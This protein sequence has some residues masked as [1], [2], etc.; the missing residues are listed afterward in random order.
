MKGVSNDFFCKANGT[1][2]HATLSR[3]YRSKEVCLIGDGHGRHSQ[4]GAAPVATGYLH[5]SYASALAAFG[6]PLAL[7]RCQGWV[8]KRPIAGS[9]AYDAMGCYPLFSC[10]DWSQLAG[11]L[12]DLAHELVSLAVVTDPFGAY[13]AALLREC[14]RD[15]VVPYKEHFVVD[16]ACDPEAFVSAHHRR[17]VQRAMQE[18]AVAACAQPEQ[19]SAE[20]N[21]LYTTLIKRHAIRGIATFSPDSF[22]Q[23]FATPGFVMLRATHRESVVGMTLWYTQGDVA[24]YHLG[25]YSE[26]GYTLRASFALFWY[27]IRYFAAQGL[28]WLG[29][30][31]GAGVEQPGT[32]GLTRFKQGW[33][34]DRRQA[35]FCGRIFDRH[36]YE[37]LVESRNIPETRYFPA[38]RLGEFS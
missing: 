27:A 17:N 2:N 19:F 24:Y 1:A 7:P 14:F 4:T 9:S 10:R 36:H 25:A 31:A 34:T 13:D 6:T 3:I 29:L 21:E 12:S 16:L 35:Y 23:Q 38:Y 37:L 15:V 33:S 8:L 22:A 20:W 32:D 28:R 5:A 11:D 30:G 26:Q 18:I